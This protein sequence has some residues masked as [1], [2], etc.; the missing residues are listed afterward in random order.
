M[1]D[2]DDYVIEST[3]AGASSTIPCE[4]GTIKKGGYVIMMDDGLE[5]SWR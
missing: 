4:A 5:R 3:D 1:S 2:N